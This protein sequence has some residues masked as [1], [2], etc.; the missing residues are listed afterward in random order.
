MQKTNIY[1]DPEGYIFQGVEHKIYQ[2]PN[3]SD[4]LIK[5]KKPCIKPKSFLRSIFRNRYQYGLYR[6]WVALYENY[7]RIVNKNGTVPSYLPSLHGFVDTNLGVGLSVR[8]VLDF[9]GCVAKTLSEYISSGVDLCFLEEAESII[10]CNTH[11][12]R[13]CHGNPLRTTHL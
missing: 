5:I 8:K 6:D 11:P 4:L 9:D 1:L 12:V 7:L 10:K 13:Y 3:D 2:N